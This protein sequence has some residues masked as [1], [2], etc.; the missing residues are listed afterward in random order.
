[1]SLVILEVLVFAMVYSANQRRKLWPRAKTTR[2]ASASRLQARAPGRPV[3]PFGDV[4][5]SNLRTRDGAV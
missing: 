1:M 5:G 4:E 3:L 2:G